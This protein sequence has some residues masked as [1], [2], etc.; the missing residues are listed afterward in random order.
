MIT[1]PYLVEHCRGWLNYAG[2]LEDPHF[3][4]IKLTLV[5]SILRPDCDYSLDRL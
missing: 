3:K 1:L 5:R 2:K 4:E